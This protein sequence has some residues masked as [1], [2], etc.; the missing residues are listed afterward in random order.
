MLKSFFKK[1]TINGSLIY[2]LN[3]VLKHI[4]Q[5]IK[6]TPIL[7][8]KSYKSSCQSIFLLIKTHKFIQPNNTP[9]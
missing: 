4:F 3:R 1:N 6:I 8:I 9:S 7:H 5:I 2:T